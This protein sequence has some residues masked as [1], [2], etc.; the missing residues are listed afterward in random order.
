MDQ[1][2]GPEGLREEQY[3]EW[4]AYLTTNSQARI[5]LFCFPYAGGGAL[6]YRSWFEYLPPEI[7]ICPIQ[8]PGRENRYNEKPYTE[9]QPL[10]HKILSAIR[11]YLDSPFAFFGHSMGATLSFELTKKL[12]A[13]NLTLP[14]H[15]FVSSR[16]GP[17]IPGPNPPLHSLP[18]SELIDALKSFGGI[19][20]LIMKEPEI[21]DFFLPTLRADICLSETYALENGIPINVP[22]TAFGGL[23]DPFTSIQE[24]EAWRKY[25]R[26]KFRLKAFPGGH[27]Y[28]REH[29]KELLKEI[30]LALGNHL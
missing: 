13:E 22:I 2:V 29:T 24:L 30:S 16:R 27:F 7:E 11:P 3:E 18:K 20:D 12:N 19:P 8:L 15:L 9:L 17:H 23:Q 10:V 6:S 5:R 14:L 25:T 4:F 1:F 26:Q 21:L 28:F